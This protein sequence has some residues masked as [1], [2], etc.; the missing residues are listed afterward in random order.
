M[1][2]EK[3]DLNG[4]KIGQGEACFIIAE[5]GV[6]H[7]G[8]IKLAL[9]L[10]K[11]AARAGADA[12]KFQLYNVEEQVLRKAKTVSYQQKRTGANLMI[13]MAKSYDLPWEAHKE[14]A[15]YCKKL[16]IMYMS[17]C[18][19]RN[20]VDFLL[21]LGCECIKVGSGEITNFPL[22][23]HM[24]STGKPILLST[25]MSELSEVA[26]AVEHIRASGKS[27]LA[28]FHCVSSYPADPSSINLHVMKNLEAIFGVPVG[29]SDHTVGNEVACA[30]VA[31]GASLIEKHFTL[32]KKLPGPDHA[33]SLNPEELKNLI[34]DIRTV[35]SA[36]GDGLKKVDTSE[37]ENRI[38]ARRGLVSTCD[39]FAGETLSETNSAFKRPAIGV[40]P[41]FYRVVIGKKVNRTIRADE[42]ITWDMLS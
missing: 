29:F 7:N 24:S 37:R 31:L 36:L 4:R 35:E 3:I 14:I 40:D 27:Q 5:A 32:D 38:A 26:E 1:V 17:S 39:I 13:E 41:R 8:D 34:D 15:E 30:A 10:V 22:L 16:N 12:V 6:N 9:Q 11:A 42:P 2:Y 25:G 19:D 28:L 18:F 33:M 23:A 20:A 21:N